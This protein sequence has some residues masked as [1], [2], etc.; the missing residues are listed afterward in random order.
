MSRVRRW[1]RNEYV[2]ETISGAK[3]ERP[4]L[5]ALL[6]D[7]ILRRFDVVV[8]WRLDRLG[9]TL[10]HLILLLEELSALDIALVSLLDGIDGTTPAGKHQLHL[11]SAIA[12]FERDRV[13]RA[14]E[15]KSK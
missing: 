6:T 12:D 15:G 7:A 3:D 14:R 11:L 13:C 9:R 10:R 4:A 1:V 5:T 8:V 2:D